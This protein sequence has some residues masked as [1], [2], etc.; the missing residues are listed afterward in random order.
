MADTEPA[1]RPVPSANPDTRP[2]SEARRDLTTGPITRTLLLFALPTLGGNVLQSLNGSINAIWVGNILGEAALAA[3]ANATTIMFLMF[4]AVFGLAMATTIL[5]GQAIGARDLDLARRTLGA[6]IGLVTAIALATATAGWI[7]TPALLRALATPPASLPLATTYL[8]V[9]FAGMPFTFMTVLLSSALRGSGDAITPLRAMILSVV[10]DAGLNPFLI[11]GIGPF[12]ALGIAGSALATLIAG[13]TTTV[14]LIAYIY[15]RDL[16]LRLK[17]GELSYLIHGRVLMRAIVAKGVPMGLSIIVL[18][19]SALAMMGLVNRA[20]VHTT[21]AFGAISQLWGYVQMPALAIGAGVSAM[22]AQ[23]IGAGRWD[24]VERIAWAGSGI[25]IVLTGVMVLVIS[26]TD[27][28]LL[29]LFL[30]PQSASV[31]IAMHIHTVVSWSFVMFGISMVLS[32]AMRANGAVIAPLVIMFVAFFPVRFG[33]AL[34]FEGRYGP[35]AIWWSF[36][37]GSIVSFVSTLAYYRW[38]GWR[39]ARMVASTG[40]RG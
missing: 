18:S 34:A 11:K 12:P 24:R 5:I 20:G 29:G 19:A 30:T 17:R 38:G 6:S 7:G 21:A 4:A 39:R 33:A 25:N 3:T 31:P 35:E 32:A 2:G 16:P 40:Q 8:R 14:F 1:L 26:L 22:V 27:R 13:A 36:P 23:N 28:P 37:L 9:I 15:V 10:L